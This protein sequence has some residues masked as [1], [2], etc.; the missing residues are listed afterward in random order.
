MTELSS[1][2]HAAAASATG[3]E[4][5]QPAGLAAQVEALAARLQAVDLASIGRMDIA[6]AAAAAT[7]ADTSR[8]LFSALEQYAAGGG[9][10]QPA[11]GEGGNCATYELFYQPEQVQHVQAAAAAALDGRL[12]RLEAALGTQSLAEAA[13]KLK[14]PDASVTAVAHAIAER[15][16]ALSEK[17]L[18]HMNTRAATVLAQLEQVAQRQ[19]DLPST[20][21]QQKVR[22]GRL[23][24]R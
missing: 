7:D 18:E 1:D 10:A 3:A 16:A 21:A 5:P 6:T 13:S 9:R 17:A 22:R 15:V 12:E 19:A 4:A 14:T 2:V 8:R 24:T 20:K 11:A 23:S